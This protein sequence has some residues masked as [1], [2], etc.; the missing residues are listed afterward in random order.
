VKPETTDPE[1]PVKTVLAEALSYLDYSEI[2]LFLQ[3]IRYVQMK[4]IWSG[5]NDTASAL[6][7]V[8]A[9]VWYG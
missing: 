8:C 2:A 7:N 5:K 4:P 1:C 6:R 3:A 9:L